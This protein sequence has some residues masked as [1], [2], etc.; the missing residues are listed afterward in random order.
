M[1]QVISAL[2]T[3]RFCL[4]SFFLVSNEKEKKCFEKRNFDVSSQISHIFRQSVNR[5]K[6][7]QNNKIED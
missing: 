5:Q 7:K 1:Q 6:Q 3:V 2:F 4:T